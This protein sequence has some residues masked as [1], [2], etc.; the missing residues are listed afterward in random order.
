[1]QTRRRAGQRAPSRVATGRLGY[2][3]PDHSSSALM[4]STGAA[5]SS[6]RPT[7]RTPTALTVPPDPDD[8]DPPPLKDALARLERLIRN[9]RL[10]QLTA[11]GV[12]WVRTRDLPRELLIAANKGRFGAGRRPA[13]AARTRDGAST[14]FAVDSPLEGTGFE[15]SVPLQSRSY[16]SRRGRWQSARKS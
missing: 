6:P 15:P 7:L 10:L 1:M 16:V 14:G 12:D 3:R 13:C 11:A 9:A 8:F 2:E 4:P 5:L